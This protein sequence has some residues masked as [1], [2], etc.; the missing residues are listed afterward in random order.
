M[1]VT[2]TSFKAAY[3]EFDLGVDSEHDALIAA[4]LAEAEGRVDRA[5]FT[6]TNADSAVMALTAHLL[7]CSPSGINARLAKDKKGEVQSL[8]LPN[9]KALARAATCL[10]GKV[11]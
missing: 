5:I 3:P 9:F 7:A 6:A 11:S 4:K 8:Y 1:A 10:L 2:A